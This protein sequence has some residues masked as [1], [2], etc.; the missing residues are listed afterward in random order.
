MRHN[1]QTG[2]WLTPFRATWH[3]TRFFGL[4]EFLVWKILTFMSIAGKTLSWLAQ[5]IDLGEWRCGAAK[6]MVCQWWP[7]SVE[8][9]WQ[10]WQVL[11]ESTKVGPSWEPIPRA[12]FIFLRS[13]LCICI[14][15]R[16]ALMANMWKFQSN[17][18]TKPSIKSLPCTKVVWQMVSNLWSK[19]K[20]AFEWK[21]WSNV[22]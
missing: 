8:R 10:V 17:D 20:D 16:F 14:D 6:G 12:D 11:L 22:L 15:C 21:N 9:R 2:R 5:W 4:T 7:H 18:R 13:Y 3:P 1:N 19:A